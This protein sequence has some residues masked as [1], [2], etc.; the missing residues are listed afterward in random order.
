M[1]HRGQKMHKELMDSI[2]RPAI[3]LGEFRDFAV[4]GCILR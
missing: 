2:R 3:G 4:S 1:A